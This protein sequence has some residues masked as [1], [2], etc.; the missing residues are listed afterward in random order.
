VRTCL[1]FPHG[2]EEAA[3]F[4]T[5]LLPNST[6]ETVSPVIV[7]FTLAGTPYTILNG[8]E[9][10][11]LTP[12]ASIMV[13][14][15]DQ[16]ETDRLWETLCVNNGGEEG[17]CGWLVDRF[18]VSWQIVPKRLPALMKSTDREAAGRVQEA[19]MKM[20]K[21]DIAMLEAAF[22]GERTEDE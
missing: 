16:E 21:I 22:R 4:Y 7:E 17:R 20:N 15:I 18:G 3:N 2:G 5:S 14:T 13:Q 10:Y 1:W 11:K 9:M 19:M 8:G 12:A 6:I